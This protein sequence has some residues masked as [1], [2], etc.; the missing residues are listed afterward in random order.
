MG[1]WVGDSVRKKWAV[2]FIKRQEVPPGGKVTL[3]VPVQSGRLMKV[4]PASFCLPR[5]F[6]FLFLA[7]TLF[8]SAKSCVVVLARSIVQRR[9]HWARV[10]P[11]TVSMH[12]EGEAFT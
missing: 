11:S 1:G 2:A 7:L 4:R 8:Y 6:L 3:P 10:S 9:L 12:H 5:V